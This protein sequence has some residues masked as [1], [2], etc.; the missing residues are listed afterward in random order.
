M[1]KSLKYQNKI[2]ISL[3]LFVIIVISAINALF[4]TYTES[5]LNRNMVANKLET[6]QKL[7]EQLDRMLTE[8][9]RLSISVNAS[10]YIMDSLSQIPPDPKVNYFDQNPKINSDIKNILLSFTS[11]QPLKGRI[12]II[13][14]YN[15]YLEVS[16]KMNSQKVTKDFIR[17]IPR[18]KMQ[19][20]SREY[21]IY[22][23]PH[24][25]DWSANADEVISIV[26]PLRDNYNVYGL[27][28]VS[29]SI[30]EL[31]DIFLFKNSAQTG[32][33][34]ILDADHQPVYGK[35]NSAMTFEWNALSNEPALES[36]Y[37][38]FEL[39]NN[40]RDIIAFFSK[41]TSIDWNLISFED[42]TVFK[43]PILYLRNSTLAVYVILLGC[44]LLALYL[45]AGRV[46]MPIRELKD[47]IANFDSENLRLLPTGL[48]TR[49]EIT[50]L[51]KAFQELLD[52]LQVS[53]QKAERA[54][55]KEVIAQMD[56]LQAQVNPHFLY[57]TLTVIGAYGKKKG[58]QEVLDMCNALA[59]ML[60]YTMKFGEKS[61]SVYFEIEHIENYL[62]L[63]NKRYQSFFSYEINI[64]PQMNRIAMPKLVLQPIIENV[65]QHA[66][67]EM[68]PPWRIEIN[69]Y[70]EGN[71]WYIE[72][73]D[74]GKGFDPDKLNQ[75]LAEI[76]T[77]RRSNVPYPMGSHINEPNHGNGIGLLNVISRLILFYHHDVRIKLFNR[78]EG[79]AVVSIGGVRDV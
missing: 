44:L 23:A 49:N 20:E 69:G 12:S 51:G 36:D 40:H 33:F 4:Y 18:V 60:R 25:D 15:D 38:S 3:A 32:N 73:M 54:H 21:K 17:S 78:P 68:D 19:M 11:L 22:L 10:N 24:Q 76:D 46:T 1:F 9:D 34:L 5:I 37:G 71:A 43:K 52:Q 70:V 64:S 45:Y 31:E 13:S 72:I 79:G 28:E 30:K 75:L 14:R 8:M 42:G 29:Y 2:F 55:V 26:R 48:R 7:Q 47:F 61:S 67:K 50:L 62:K 41:L 39:K 56:A 57:N 74:N 59:D 77:M 66:F 16:N 63:M 27:V 65:F 35:L 58:N 53:M 6:I